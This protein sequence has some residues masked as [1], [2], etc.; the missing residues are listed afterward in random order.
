MALRGFNM[1]LR[2]LMTIRN[3]LEMKQLVLELI[4]EEKEIINRKFK[5]RRR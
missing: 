4:K 3:K 2:Y 1:V 5:K